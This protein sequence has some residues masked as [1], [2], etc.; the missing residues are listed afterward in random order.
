[1]ATP[2]CDTMV[3]VAMPVAAAGAACVAPVSIASGDRAGAAGPFELA[4]GGCVVCDV[5]TF[6]PVIVGGA[7]LEVAWVALT[8]APEV[9][10][11]PPPASGSDGKRLSLCQYARPRPP[12]MTTPTA[13]VCG[14]GKLDQNDALVFFGIRFSGMAGGVLALRVSDAGVSACGFFFDFI[15]IFLLRLRL[16]PFAK[17]RTFDAHLGLKMR[18]CKT[19]HNINFSGP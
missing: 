19:W 16:L 6:V 2:G 15:V 5:V 14:C 11:P 10:L 12:T 8:L 9:S 1:M 17:C 13:V 7:V 4:A 18:R 3:G